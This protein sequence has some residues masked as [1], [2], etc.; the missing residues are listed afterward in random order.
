LKSGLLGASAS[1]P[2]FATGAG[3]FVVGLAVGACVFGGTAPIGVICAAAGLAIP[4]D[5]APV[6][7]NV[8]QLRDIGL[9]LFISNENPKTI[10]PLQR[11]A[12][13]RQSHGRHRRGKSLR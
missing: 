13:P 12:I 5:S 2:V 8:R 7:S 3:A 10:Q 1:G 9:N 6:M 4:T 11:L